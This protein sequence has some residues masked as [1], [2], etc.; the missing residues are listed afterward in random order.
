M[1]SKFQLTQN[2][3]QIITDDFNLLGEV[4]G[5][6]DDRVLAELFRV[7]PYDGSTTSKGILSYSPNFG[8][9]ALIEPNGASGQVK[10][11]PFRAVVGSRTAVGLDAKKN[12]RDIRSSIF[13]G[14]TMLHQTLAIGANSSG[15]PRWD[16]VYAAVAVDANGATVT[17]KVK[18]PTTKVIAGASV[19]TTLVTNVT[20][21]VQPGTAAA[22]PTWPAVPSDTGSVYYI[23]LAYIRVPDGFNGT[24][25]V[26]TSDIALQAPLL[27]MTRAAGGMSF[28]VCDSNHTVSSAEQQAWGSTGTRKRLWMPPDMAG[29]ESLLVVMD[30]STSPSSTWSHQS[31]GVV[32]S[33]NWLNRVCRWT[34]YVGPGGA[35]QGDSMPW[36]EFDL[37]VEPGTNV[38]ESITGF[39]STIAR[40]DGSGASNSVIARLNGAQFFNMG[41]NP[42][43]EVY[44]YADRAD[45]GKIKV[46]I[47]G[48]PAATIWLWLDFTGPYTNR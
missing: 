37:I 1:E 42:A 36:N 45:G 48:T 38:T 8:T 20:V 6:A 14:S 17:R 29:A 39:G 22:S 9:A 12:W 3:Q 10:V 13:V 33:R 15:N 7:T 40:A 11:N 43:T 34:C 24:S 44:F 26:G 46:N 4:A 47:T 23:P 30:L 19:V 16:L 21:A 31:G 25:T 27:R 2:G 32:D 5:L 28:S 41:L 18:N 35:T